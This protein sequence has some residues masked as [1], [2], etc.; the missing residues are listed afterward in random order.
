M[1]GTRTAL[2]ASWLLLSPAVIVSLVFFVAPLT[3]L[4]VES[5][6]KFSY[7]GTSDGITL[8]NYYRILS[9][10]YFIGVIGTTFRLAA[11][12]TVLCLVLGY[13]VALL[14]KV[15]PARYK[16]I[17]VVA[18][19]APLLVSSIVRTFGWIIVLG[20][21]GLLNS[22][23]QALGMRS[24]FAFRNHLFSDEAVIVGLVHLY[25]PF[26][27]LALYSALQKQPANLVNAARNLGASRL[28][29]FLAVT[30][31]I[32]IPGIVAGATTVFALS[33][34]AYVTVA[35]LGGSK[36]MV[37]SILSYQQSIALGNWPL[38]AAIGIVLLITTL[39]IIQ[40]FQAFVRRVFP[41]EAAST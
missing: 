38:G 35:V 11:V 3:Y 24:G 5:F 19:I 27:I 14:L 20:E 28:R 10:S 32:S 26:M 40:L 23:L 7:L 41:Q 22:F 8:A 1:N 17:F 30:L 37:L 25:I 2:T 33:A 36:I 15:T 34:G 6:Y 13:P 39:I 21:H 12:T 29:A 31:P 16:G 9:D 18:I 4:V